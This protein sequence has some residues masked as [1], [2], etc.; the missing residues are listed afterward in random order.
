MDEMPDVPLEAINQL[1]ALMGNNSALKPRDSFVVESTIKTRGNLYKA[2]KEGRIPGNSYVEWNDGQGALR[3]NIL[4]FLTQK[5]VSAV[6]PKTGESVKVES[7]KV[8]DR[9]WR[10]LY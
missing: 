1:A 3:V 8:P 9:S 7:A 5:V 4:D 2:L 6:D 10:V